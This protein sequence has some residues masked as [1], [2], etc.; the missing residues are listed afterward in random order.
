MNAAHEHAAGY[1][2]LVVD[3]TVANRTLVK[4]Y[5]GR[6]GFAVLTAENGR[7]ALD[8]FAREQ[9][10]IVLMDV[11]MPV[12]DGHEATRQIRERWPERWV[13]VVMLS[14][15]GSESDLV[16]G[17]ETGADDY[18]VKPLS[19]QVFAAKMR[20]LV[21]SLALQRQTEAALAR[22]QAVSQAMSDA[23]V[24]F[25]GEGRIEAGNPALSALFGRGPDH[26]AGTSVYALFESPGAEAL[27]SEVGAREAGASGL[28]QPA[29]RE[30]EACVAGGVKVAVELALSGMPQPEGR[31]YLAVIRNVADRKAAERELAASAR[32][33]QRYHDDAEREN[34]LALDILDRQTRLG[35]VDDPRV[36]H[37]VVPAQRFSGDVVLSAFA[38]DGRLFA[39]L[40]DA[41]GHG[42]SAAVSVLPAVSEFYRLVAT[43]PRAAQCVAALNS[44]LLDVLPRGR[45]VAAALVCADLSSG[46]AQV[47][48]GGTP[49]VLHLAPDGAVRAR[50]EA[51]QI[52]MGI[53]DFRMEDIVLSPVRLA[54]GE[55][56]VLCSDGLLEAA[57]P[58]GAQFGYTAFEAALRSAPPADRLSAVREAVSR[59]CEGQSPHDD[60]SLLII[61]T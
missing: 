51:T 49:A 21:R 6:L 8:V 32:T 42:L 37:S 33:L 57:A 26:Y 34:A 47:W 36:Q 22:L 10:D 41:T 40:A 16:S 27:R 44:V 15:L 19:Y 58:D 54:P 17:L 24:I 43:A 20:T 53:D 48:V 25:D 29:M 13:P 50:C 23:L 60:V 12:M 11:M 31:R 18:L 56:L 30:L 7:E 5:L 1:R 2:V 28:D 61:G 38:P 35:F 39:L 14:A 9:P 3:D 59:H 46:E 45:F 4:A 52:P 55:Q